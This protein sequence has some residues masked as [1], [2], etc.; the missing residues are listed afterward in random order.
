M[1]ESI[2]NEPHEPGKQAE[3]YEKILIKLQVEKYEKDRSG[4]CQVQL[5]KGF[6][7]DH[8]AKWLLL[9]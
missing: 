5:L 9:T 6:V 4:H 3:V 1:I 7:E 8:Q 2:F